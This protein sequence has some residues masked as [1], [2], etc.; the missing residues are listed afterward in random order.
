MILEGLAPLHLGSYFFILYLESTM[1]NQEFCSL[2]GWEL[3]AHKPP[4]QIHIDIDSDVQH[5]LSTHYYVG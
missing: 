4:L 5:S 3:Y 1:H 2:S